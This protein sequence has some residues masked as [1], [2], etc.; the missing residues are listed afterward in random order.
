MLVAK[1]LPTGE[2]SGEPVA[3]LESSIYYPEETLI[4]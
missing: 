4:H 2:P 3:D 1:I